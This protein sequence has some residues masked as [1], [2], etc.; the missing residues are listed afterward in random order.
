MYKVYFIYL[1]FNDR[2]KN[3]VFVLL[4]YSGLNILFILDQIKCFRYVMYVCFFCGG[5][6]FI[7]VWG[8][9]YLWV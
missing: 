5:F 9:K 8:I 7:D 2:Y 1:F 3:V 6:Y 4:N